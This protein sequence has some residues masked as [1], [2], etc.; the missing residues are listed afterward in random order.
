MRLRDLAKEI[1]ER[2]AGH[3]ELSPQVV[4]ATLRALGEILVEDELVLVTEF[5]YRERC[6]GEPVLEP[7]R[8]FRTDSPSPAINALIGAGRKRKYGKFQSPEDRSSAPA[9][10]P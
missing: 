10:H 7:E 5:R 4:L 6:F 1:I 9:L 3:V 2:Q 8:V